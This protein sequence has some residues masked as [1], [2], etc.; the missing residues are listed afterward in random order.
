M[1]NKKGFETKTDYHVFDFGL[2]HSD[3]YK[4]IKIW[5]TNKSYVPA[6]WK[7]MYVKFPEK[8]YHGAATV[9]LEERENLEK[10]DDPDV[11]K[12]D[13]SEVCNF[14]FKFF[15]GKMLGNYNQCQ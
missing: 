8:K 14:R 5:V 1:L 10:V 11:F 7:I 13:T 2:C 12:F 6:H 4:I 3:D 15:L 9:T